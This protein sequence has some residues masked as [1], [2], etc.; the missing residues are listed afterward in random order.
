MGTHLKGLNKSFP[1]NTN[2]AGFKR[3]SKLSAFLYFNESTLSIQGVKS[4]NCISYILLALSTD[5]MTKRMWKMSC[6]FVF[7]EFWLLHQ[8]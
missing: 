1:M 7:V 4:M 8:N 6:C 3:F 2:M 5:E